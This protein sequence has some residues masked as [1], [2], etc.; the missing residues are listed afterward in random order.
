MYD[1][2]YPMATLV[3]LTFLM[4]S[5][6]LILRIKAVRNRKISPR[7]FKLNEGGKEPDSLNA[8]T[9]CYNNL[10][11]LPVLFYAVCIVAIVINKSS[12]YFVLLAWSYV[13]FRYIHAFILSTYNHILH[14]LYAFSLSC[15]FLFAMWVKVA[16]LS[17]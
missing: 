17:F 15:I 2:V 11:E 8:V 16:L 14:R 6:M 1:L 5:L 3:G 9:Q 10:L 13:V 12:D 7:Y 4:L